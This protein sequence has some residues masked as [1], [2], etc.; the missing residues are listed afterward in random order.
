MKKI[1]IAPG[2]LTVSVM[3][4]NKPFENAAIKGNK[5]DK[6]EIMMMRNNLVI[7]FAFND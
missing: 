5:T 4:Q 2:L 6:K 7:T 1:L 3:K